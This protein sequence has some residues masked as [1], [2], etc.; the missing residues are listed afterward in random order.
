MNFDVKTWAGII[1]TTLSMIGGGLSWTYSA[2][3]ETGK[4]QAQVEF[5]KTHEQ[6]VTDLITTRIE[7]GK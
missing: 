4:L 3:K 6:L 7:C 1:L 2:A 5:N